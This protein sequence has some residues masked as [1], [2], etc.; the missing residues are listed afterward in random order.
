MQEK[1]KELDIGRTFRPKPIQN[2][3]LS[4][5]KFLKTDSD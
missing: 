5:Q 4:Y 1:N 3:V 2:T